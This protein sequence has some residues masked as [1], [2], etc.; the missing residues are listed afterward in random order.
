[1]SLFSRRETTNVYSELTAENIGLFHTLCGNFLKIYLVGSHPVQ[2][3]A[4]PR[5]KCNLFVYYLTVY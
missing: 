4:K 3:S 1:M 2:I 5:I